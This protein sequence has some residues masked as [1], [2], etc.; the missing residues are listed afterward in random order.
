MK[1]FMFEDYINKENPE[2][3]QIY[4]PEILTRA[5]AAEDM[6]AY[7]RP[8]ASG[9]TGAIPLSCQTGIRNYCD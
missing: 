9:Q 5:H 6:G 1:F 7:V 2:P 3:G 8:A 4:R